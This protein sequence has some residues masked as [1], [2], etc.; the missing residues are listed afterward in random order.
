[1]TRARERGWRSRGSRPRGGRDRR[2]PPRARPPS[3]RGAPRRAPRRAAGLRG[4]AARRPRACGRARPIRWTRSLIGAGPTRPSGSPSAAGERGRPGAAAGEIVLP[5][6]DVVVELERDPHRVEQARE[7][8]EAPR[9][10]PRRGGQGERRGQPDPLLAVGDRQVTREGHGLAAAERG[11]L[12]VDRRDGLAL[13]RRVR[14][15]LHACRAGDPVERGVAPVPHLFQQGHQRRGGLCLSIFEAI[16][17]ERLDDGEQVR[18][19]RVADEILRERRHRFGDEERRAQGDLVREHL[20]PGHVARRREPER[21]GEREGGLR[22]RLR[23]GRRERPVELVE[24]RERAHAAP[25]IVSR[26]STLS[27]ATATR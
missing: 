8:A 18:E 7:A 5:V 24:D 3:G 23:Q 26:G 16:G 20:A 2:G 13:G 1:M 17:A 27:T 11:L 12:G 6:D 19:R 14:G 4:S 15:H 9:V 22:E 21:H 10:P 25:A